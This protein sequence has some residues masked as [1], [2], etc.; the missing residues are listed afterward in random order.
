MKKLLIIVLLTI[1]ILSN[2]TTYYV[3]PSGSNSNAGTS[4]SP[5]GSLNYAFNKLVAGD[6]LYVRG[7]TYTV[8]ANGSYGISVS[9]KNGTSSN[10]IS[11][12]AYTGEFPVLNCSGLNSSSG[13]RDGLIM[14]NCSYWS[15]KGL[16][17]MN[18]HE[19]ADNL[20][21]GSVMTLS[22]CNNI[23]LEQVSGHDCGN[24]FRVFG[25]DEIRYLNCD[26]YQNADTKDGG[27]LA[28]GFWS[29][30]TG[31]GHIYYDGCRSF[32]N[33]D[34]GWD[35]FA[36]GY[37]DGYI[38]YNKCW[39]FENGAW[40]GI[41]GNGAGFKTGL[42]G[43]PAIGGVQRTLTNCLSF[44]NNMGFDESQDEG[45]GYSIPQV[46][47]N[48][49]SYNN[50]ACGFNFQFGA[51]VDGAFAV[52]IFRNNISYNDHYVKYGDW[53]LA[54]NLNTQDH[55][56]WNGLT[57]NDATFQSLDSKQAKGA[58]LA[59]G[60]LPEITFLHLSSAST[61]IN[62][63]VALGLP[64]AGSA[65]DLGAFETQLTINP[66]TPVYS[67]ATVDNATPSIVGMMYNLALAGIVPPAS[68]FS[69]KVNSVARNV[70]TVAVSGAKVMLTLASPAVYGDVITV[71]YTVPSANPLQT[72]SGGMA[73]TISAQAVANN[74]AAPVVSAN[75]TIK[76]T[77]SPNTVH[78]IIN[79]QLVYTSTLPLLSAF[80]SPELIRIFDK[81]GKLVI[82]KSLVIGVT[83]VQIPINLKHGIYNVQ[84]LAGGVA[85]ATQKIMVY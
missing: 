37:G 12:L 26:S 73:A 4:T 11:V 44:S 56:S 85:M 60:S 65:P 79:I 33:S 84:V 46:I 20:S 66:A 72:A 31:G 57:V 52:D 82:E 14:S 3:S 17:I 36:T 6:I 45:S 32:L 59:D 75:A 35:A 70:N 5:W 51:G 43:K 1:P 9:G 77:I 8:M 71:A 41:T 83:N 61:L 24:G 55:N 28:N 7:G 16:N 69:V 74:I 22:Y 39:S 81:Y 19:P 13:D 38:S 18:V 67:G 76:M 34:D 48:C 50:S 54:N 62:T 78:H 68:A 42:C 10:R 21:P 25:G 23:T 49:T 15:I 27:D 30:V 29:R 53:G 40:N 63:G 64:Y 2:A 80:K 47:Y 58:R